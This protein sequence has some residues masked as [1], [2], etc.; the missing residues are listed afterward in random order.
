M[1]AQYL[2]QRQSQYGAGTRSQHDRFANLQ[3]TAVITQRRRMLVSV[4]SIDIITILL[5][6][7]LVQTILFTL[8]FMLLLGHL[9]HQIQIAPLACG[10]AVAYEASCW[11]QPW[12]GQ[13]EGRDPH[14]CIFQLPLLQQWLL[15]LLPSLLVQLLLQAAFL[16]HP[17]AGWPETACHH[18][19]ILDVHNS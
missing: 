13:T 19:P 15:V 1:P 16:M 7:I 3:H 10:V 12:S 4:E 18:K 6:I 9:G 14:R 8:L 5:V 2:S 11:H 17:V